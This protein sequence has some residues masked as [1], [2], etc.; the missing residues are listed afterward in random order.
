MSAENKNR[1]LLDDEI[2]LRVTAPE[3]FQELIDSRTATLQER[4]DLEELVAWKEIREQNNREFSEL[5]PQEIQAVLARNGQISPEMQSME[6]ASSLARYSD[7]NNIPFKPEQ[8]DPLQAFLGYEQI[9]NEE[10]GSISLPSANESGQIIGDEEIPR[11]DMRF[12]VA[13]EIDSA[14]EY[15]RSMTEPALN[16]LGTMSREAKDEFLA[17]LKLAGKEALKAQEQS[18]QQDQA[19]SIEPPD[20][21]R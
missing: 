1:S 8:I 5:T 2:H 21:E 15:H 9:R 7:Q 13:R 18:I 14:K 4:G 12:V 19:R 17:N 3:F 10:R 20:R 6:F 11:E 16:S